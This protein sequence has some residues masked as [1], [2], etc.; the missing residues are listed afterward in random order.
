MGEGKQRPKWG[1][2]AIIRDEMGLVMVSAEWEMSGYGDAQ[3]A[4]AYA[5]LQTVRLAI[6][7]GFKRMVFEGDNEKVFNLVQNDIS[8]IRSYLGRILN[9]IQ[10]LQSQID[11]CR[12]SVISRAANSVAHNLAH[13]AHSD[14]NRI[15]IEEVPYSTQEVYFHDLA[16]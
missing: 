12:F 7:C 11:T 16:H 4:E 3:L 2:G 13:L 14:P 10:K 6:D 1:L 8:D 5:L 15:W 9:E